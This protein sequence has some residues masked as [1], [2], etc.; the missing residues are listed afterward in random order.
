[1]TSTVLL[2]RVALW[3]HGVT[4]V[5]ESDGLAGLAF[6]V[7]RDHQ[8]FLAELVCVFLSIVDDLYGVGAAAAHDSLTDL[9][10]H[11]GGVLL[12]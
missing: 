7:G 6:L 4:L 10:V 12:R 11:H 9:S 1:M 2:I 8:G 3:F 5:A